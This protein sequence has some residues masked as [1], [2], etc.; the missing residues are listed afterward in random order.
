M[1]DKRDKGK[2][3]EQQRDV[4]EQRDKVYD[5]CFELAVTKHIYNIFHLTFLLIV[6]IKSVKY[7]N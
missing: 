7:S 1:D 3:T 2:E 4:L 5:P 6:F